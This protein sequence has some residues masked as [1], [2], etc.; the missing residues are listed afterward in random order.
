MNGHLLIVHGR[1]GGDAELGNHNGTAVLN[2]SL[3]SNRYMGA[4][5]DPITMWTRCSIWGPRAESLAQYLTKGT[6]LIVNGSLIVEMESGGPR[7]YQANNGEVRASY[8]M[9][10][11]TVEFC[12]GRANQD[13]GA[14]DSYSSPATKAKSNDIPF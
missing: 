11:D 8:E 5:K 14:N 1:L 9:R 2:F 6:E 3:A 12:G 4:D 13:A 7:T 10:V